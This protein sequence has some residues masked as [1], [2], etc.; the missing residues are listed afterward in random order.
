MGSPVSAQYAISARAGL[1]NYTTGPV[2]FS[3]S[4]DP[5]WREI[6]NHLQLEANDRIKTESWAKA[7][8]LL[9]PGSY[10]RLG[11]IAEVAVVSTDLSATV[12]QLLSGSAVLEAGNLADG[13]TIT[14]RTPFSQVQIKKDGLYRIDVASDAMTLSVRQ[15]EASIAKP[16]GAQEKIKKN[17]RVLVTANEWQMAKLDPN[18]SDEVDLWSADRAELLL[19]ANQSFIRRMGSWSWPSLSWSAWVFDPFFGCYTFFPWGSGFESVYG[20]GSYWPW[21]GRG[22]CSNNGGGG[23]GGGSRPTPPSPRRE[24]TEVT[25]GVLLSGD[26]IRNYPDRGMNAGRAPK[27]FGDDSRSGSFGSMGGSGG[28]GGSGGHTGVAPSGS[29]GG[30]VR[31]VGNGKH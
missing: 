19:A 1:V 27:S 23:A 31:V 10:M 14:V 13:A 26:R 5:T 11:N 28:R 2:S 3:S 21:W 12:L 6:P 7:E 4:S 16:D 18:Q 22:Y 9:N 8:I 24:K 25:N 30:G 29:V 20:Y 17:K 15:G